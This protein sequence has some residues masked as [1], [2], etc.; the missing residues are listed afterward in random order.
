MT[1]SRLLFSAALWLSLLSLCTGLSGG[2][3]VST[4]APPT[5]SFGVLAQRSAV[6]TAQYWNPILSYV[7]QQTGVT[8][9]LKTAR[10]ANESRE[11]TQRGDYDFVYSNHIFHPQLAPAGY[12]VIL[13]PRA[14][15]ITAQIVTQTDSPLQTLTALQG[16][17]VGFPTQIGFTGYEVPMDQLLRENIQVTPVFGGNQE[18]IMAQFK[19]GSLVA[20]AANSQVLASFAHREQLTYR[21]LWESKPYL[22]LPIA[23]HP[24]VPADIASRVQMALDDMNTNPQGQATLAASALV[25][26]Q[27][28]PFGFRAASQADYQNYVEFYQH[29]LVK[30]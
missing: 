26:G 6:L 4:P 18:G 29:S 1:R 25:I 7:E 20:I 14:A 17:K 12:Q 11:T 23:V 9:Q 28:P 15:A 16:Q 3:T 30:P 22:N 2:Q 10:T 19:A 27:Q 8:L 13:C 21:V 5:Y 24:R